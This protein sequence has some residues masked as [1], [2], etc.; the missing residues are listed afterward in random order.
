MPLKFRP[1]LEK[2]V[3]LMLHL[4][5]QCP[6]AD[7]Y[8]AVK[9]FYLADREHLKRYGRPITY[10]KYYAMEYGPVASTVLDL[11]NGK[12]GVLKPIGLK[13]LPFGTEA[14]RTPDGKYATTFIR[15]P[16]REIDRDMFSRS[17]LAV[18]DEV[19]AKY[20]DA[21]FDDLFKATHEHFAWINA[22]TTRRYGERAEMYYE[23][24]IEDEGK[25][26]ALVSDI[27]PV[28]AHMR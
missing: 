28:A 23:E 3:E 17:D 7:K 20:K 2:I 18:F 13:E 14:G 25:R 8:Q 26:E 12:L 21:S 1:K 16:K 4:A 10:E 5:H 22:W 15:Q 6:G 9:F 19:V 24:M 27:E 11:L